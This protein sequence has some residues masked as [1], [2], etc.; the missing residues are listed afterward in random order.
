MIKGLISKYLTKV[1]GIDYKID[2]AISSYAICGIVIRRVLPL[3]RGVLRFRKMVFLGQNVVLRSGG[4]IRLGSGCSVGDYSE[5][6]GLSLSGIRIGK[7]VSLGRMGKIRSTATLMVLGEGVK[8]GDY[9]GMGDG[10]YLGGFGGISIGS[11][12]IVGERLTVHSDNHRFDNEN[13]LIRDQGVEGRPVTI[14]SDCWIGSN[15]TILGGVQIG[16]GSVI[17]AGSLV[18]RSFAK[19]SVIAGC[20][21]S[22]LRLRGSGEK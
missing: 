8:V 19:N 9:V 22:L 12:T 5:L 16:S 17:G 4:G 11:N 2:N 7:G 14:G 15:V 13:I 6:D 10:F 21:A 1:K 3:V 18:T 20:P